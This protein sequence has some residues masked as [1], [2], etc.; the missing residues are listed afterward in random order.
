MDTVKLNNRFMSLT[1][2]SP[3]T[4]GSA[5]INGQFAQ[6]VNGQYVLSA[7][8][9]GLTCA[10]VPLVNSLG[11]RVTCTKHADLVARIAARGV[12]NDITPADEPDSSDPQT[13][14]TLLTSLIASNFAQN[15]LGTSTA[16][17]GQVASLTSTNN[18]INWCATLPS[19]P[20]TNGQQLKDGSC[21]PTPMGAI[22][23]SSN[24]PSCKFVT[25]VNLAVIPP[26]TTFQITLAVKNFA[27][28]YFVSLDSSYFAAP[29]QLD[30]NT[31][32]IQGH[33]HVVIE[34]L[35]SLTQTAPTDPTK[36]A[37]FAAI[38]SQADANGYLYV[39]VTGGLPEGAYRMTTM[40]SA[41]NHQPLVSPVAERGASDDT[42]YFTV[43]ATA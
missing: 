18:F 11:T 25:P 43:A 12:T 32:F 6:C 1:E 29:Q 4:T 27:T 10:A 17:A 35:E 24:I 15:G 21:N 33:A 37:F 9:P 30:P 26:Y 34:A 28:G 40:N 42:I 39:S 14:L 23:A 20:N 19:L 8:T 2:T 31:G 3:C 7:C 16:E 22:P 13:S 36:F 38:G 41:M 5:C